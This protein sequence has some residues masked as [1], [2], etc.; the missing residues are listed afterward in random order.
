MDGTI[1]AFGI[2]N[3]IFLLIGYFIREIYEWGKR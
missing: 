2:S 1:I 3:A